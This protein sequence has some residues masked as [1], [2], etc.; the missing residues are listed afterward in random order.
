MSQDGGTASVAALLWHPRAA[1]GRGRR[2]SLTLDRIA[3]ATVDIADVDG[4]TAVSVQRV[5]E[6]L[7]VTKMALY[8]YLAAKAEL[9]AVAVDAAQGGPPDLDDAGE[10]WRPRLDRWARLQHESWRRHPWLPAAVPGGRVLGPNEL[11]WIDRAVAALGDTGLD[12]PQRLDAVLLLA[13]HVR[14]APPGVSTGTQP[15]RAAGRPVL[16]RLLEE[17][18]EFPAVLAATAAPRSQGD[19]GWEFGL[20]VVLDGL[21]AAVRDADTVYA[22]N[23]SATWGGDG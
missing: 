5:A 1:P 15:W 19:G 18:G 20:R 8:R 21:A 4:L 9:L 3:A 7:G 17:R 12:G 22:G 11:A 23:G 13:G 6:R 16:R 2:P 14:A 10:G